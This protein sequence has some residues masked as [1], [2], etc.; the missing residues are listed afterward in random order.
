MTQVSSN[1]A[2]QRFFY[3]NY[4]VVREQSLV[5]YSDVVATT[6]KT[7]PLIGIYHQLVGMHG[8]NL[9]IQW[10][11]E[12]DQR[13]YAGFMQRLGSQSEDQPAADTK[14]FEP[15]PAAS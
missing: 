3:F 13:N 2:K 5:K 11:T 8:P 7:F 9:S 14:E 12:I 15:E 10:W 6:D 1:K 4:E